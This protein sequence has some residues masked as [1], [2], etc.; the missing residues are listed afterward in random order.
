LHA[1]AAVDALRSR[2]FLPRSA[3]YHR[4]PRVHGNCMANGSLS[5]LT[6]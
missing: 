2:R 5:A 4:N 6:A 1:T 3:P